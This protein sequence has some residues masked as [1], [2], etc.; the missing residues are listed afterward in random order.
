[1]EVRQQGPASGLRRERAKGVASVAGQERSA[2]LLRGH[3]NTGKAGMV[4][5][6]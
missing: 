5:R 4:I 2:D 3:I 6:I 1:M